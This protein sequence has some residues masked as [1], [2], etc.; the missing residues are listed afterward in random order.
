MKTTPSGL[1][2]REDLLWQNQRARR[3]VLRLITVT[4]QF[5]VLLAGRLP[6]ADVVPWA[7]DFDEELQVPASA[8]N[9]V[10][11]YAGGFHGVALRADGTV[12]VWGN[13]PRDVGIR[14]GG[15]LQPPADLSNVVSVA[16][17]DSFNVA[18]RSDGRLVGW[19]GNDF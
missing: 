13:Q 2:C 9:V 11:I 8:T 4:G 6:A 19:G 10:A 3:R 5:C 1:D 12:V 16:A 17:G 18:L 7:G 14:P 15:A